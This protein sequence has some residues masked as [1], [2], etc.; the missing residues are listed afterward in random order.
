MT[1]SVPLAIRNAVAS[2]RLDAGS[3]NTKWYPLGNVLRRE[4]VCSFINRFIYFR[5]ADERGKCIFEQ[6][7]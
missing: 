1:I 6:F 7:E 2:A 4:K 5:R 3:S